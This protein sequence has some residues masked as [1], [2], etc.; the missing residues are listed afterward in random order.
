MLVGDQRV[1]KIEIMWVSSDGEGHGG[2][3]EA[4]IGRRKHSRRVVLV[5]FLCPSM[6]NK[7]R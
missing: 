6:A 2:A 1:K 3:S 5:L 7:L 4:I